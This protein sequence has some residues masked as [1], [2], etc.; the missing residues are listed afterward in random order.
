MTRLTI[1]LALSVLPMAAAVASASEGNE[2]DLA[3]ADR[4][5]ACE[6]ATHQS[7]H[8][9]VRGFTIEHSVSGLDG[10]ACGYRQSMPGGMHMECRLSESG[11]A[12]LAREFREMAQ[13]RMSGSTGEQDAW[14]RECEI[15]T[16]DG[17]RLPVGPA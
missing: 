16:A 17:K 14:T 11:R 13:G 8:P 3:F 10:D 5:E 15:V 1:A 4:V 7:P 9:F 2:A 12:G 6:A